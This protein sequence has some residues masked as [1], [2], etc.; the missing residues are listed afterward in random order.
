MNSFIHDS[1][2]R[3]RAGI[4]PWCP[5]LLLSLL[6]SAL[7][8][9]FMYAADQGS[10]ILY[11]SPGGFSVRC[12]VVLHEDANQ[13]LHTEAGEIVLHS[14]VGT[15]NNTT[16]RVA[17]NDVPP[18]VIDNTTAS[19]TQLLNGARDEALKKVSGSLVYESDLVLGPYH[20]REFVVLAS[21]HIVVVDRMFLVEGRMYQ[22]AVAMPAA[23]F[24]GDAIDAAHRFVESFR[25]TAVKKQR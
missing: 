1:R 14:F 8:S 21:K 25:L 13:L 10:T 20:G 12:P 11:N 5:I 16:Y 6:I 24:E 15:L 19:A 23:D 3:Q 22:V 7:P 2:N 4:A 9:E 17:Y 18:Y